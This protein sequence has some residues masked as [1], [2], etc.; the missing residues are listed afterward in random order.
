MNCKYL[1]IEQ[2]ERLCG[3]NRHERPTEDDCL[4]CQKAG[5]DSIGGL[6]DA[7]AAAIS[8][9]KLHRIKKKD[10][11]CK[12]RQDKLNNVLKRKDEG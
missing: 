7:V 6:G 4:K 3:L 2:N 8:K 5:Q 11:N 9:S 10:C 1:Q 12:K